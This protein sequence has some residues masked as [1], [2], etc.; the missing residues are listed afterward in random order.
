MKLASGWPHVVEVW[1]FDRSGGATNIGQRKKTLPCKIETVTLSLNSINGGK[2]G[3]GK[4]LCETEELLPISLLP[5]DFCKKDNSSGFQRQFRCRACACLMESTNALKGHLDSAK[6][7][8]RFT[9]FKEM[10]VGA[11]L[12]GDVE[13]RDAVNCEADVSESGQLLSVS[14]THLRAH[15]T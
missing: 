3:S 13:A 5:K 10:E 1:H 2:L 12:N 15:E 9:V 4:N 7:K 11:A 6:H 8:E 14:Y